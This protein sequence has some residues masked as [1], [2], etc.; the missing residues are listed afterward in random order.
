MDPHVV[1]VSMPWTTLVQPSLGL[2]TLQSE[3]AAQ[4]VRCTI[5]HANIDLLKFVT[6]TTYDAVAECWGLNDFVFTGLLD[7]LDQH[8]IQSLMMQ[9][10]AKSDNGMLPEYGSAPRLADLLLTLRNSVVPTYVEEVAE[11]ILAMEPTMVG[12]TCMFD[13][14][15]ASVAVA[16]QLRLERPELLTVL[17]GYAVQHDAGE[18]VLRTFSC[19]DAI[20]R[21]DGE[22]V[23]AALASA[24]VGGEALN[25]IPGVL[26]RHGLA[27][28]GA[29][30]ARRANLTRNAP[31]D[32][33]N[34][35]DDTARLAR[36][37][38][39]T[40]TTAGLPIEGSRG[41]WWGQKS[42]CVFCGIDDDTLRYRAK[43][44][45]Q[46]LNELDTLAERYG[47]SMSF[48]F[49]DYILPHGVHETLLPQL[50]QREPRFHLEA[51]MKANQTQAK[52]DAFAD[53]GF[54][55]LQPGLESFS[56]LTLERMCKGV[57]GIHNVQ[58]L[59]WAHNAGVVIDYNILY[60]LPGDTIEEYEWLVAN[61]PRLYHLIPPISRTE[62]I[63]TR[64]APL[65]QD[66]ARFGIAQQAVH[67]PCYD[68]VFSQQML[69][70]TG[71]DFDRYCYYFDRHFEYAPGLSPLYRQ[72]VMQIEHWKKQHAERDVRLTRQFDG[73]FIEVVDSRY[74]APLEFRLEGTVAAVYRECDDHFIA[75]HELLDRL[76]NQG[77]GAAA[78]DAA[79]DTLDHHRLI[80]RDGALV[81]GLAT[82]AQATAKRELSRWKRRWKG[83]HV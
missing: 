30:P 50:S 76:D 38:A 32:F 10:R 53:A 11:K 44:A 22:P 21:G 62:T 75:M 65:Q 4:N 35:Y 52:I 19:I 25:D 2:A 9:C 17:G 47:H 69:A 79:L 56:S 58:L 43:P 80:W 34:W 78:V 61:T 49:S 40:V 81:V 67:H 77:I 13:Q 14:T 54:E 1:L 20:A 64:F 74:G 66:P 45:A 28:G 31:P 59:K 23:I 83:L 3:L 63:I 15:I 36:D 72:L 7:D 29:R 8:Q 33:A 57:R 12:F 42:H 82:D 71:F 68:V 60:G 55:S 26:T 5:Y 27:N 39:V 48:R 73:A 6:A 24:S 46:V 51:E 18:E 16:S 70:R 37:H 41:C